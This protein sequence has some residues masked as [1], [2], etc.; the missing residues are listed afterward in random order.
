[1]TGDQSGWSEE[2]DVD[3]GID[4]KEFLLE[5]QIKKSIGNIEGLLS[6]VVTG[7]VS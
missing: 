4:G 1:M 7:N 3:D 6:K 2:S 5:H